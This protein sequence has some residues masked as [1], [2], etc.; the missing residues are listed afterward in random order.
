MVLAQPTPYYL[1]GKEAEQQILM[2]EAAVA[3][4]FAPLVRF[5]LYQEES[6][7][8]VP[9]IMEVQEA[10]LGL[11]GMGRIFKPAAGV[12]LEARATHPK[13]GLVSR[14]TSLALRRTMLVGGVLEAVATS[15]HTEA[16]A[17]WEGVAMQVHL[18][19][20]IQ[21]EE[22]GGPAVLIFQ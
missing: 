5:A 3:Q 6:Q 22:A 1:K 10:M 18:E 2:A 17:G 7:I 11:T 15:H 16:A 12:E 19:F 14:A 4:T 21:E 8:K 13:E 9:Q 20:Q